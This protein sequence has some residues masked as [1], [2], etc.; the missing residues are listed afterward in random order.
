MSEKLFIKKIYGKK[1]IF[2]H[3]VNLCL[4]L[5]VLTRWNG[6]YNLDKISEILL[7]EVGL[8]CKRKKLLL[9][10]FYIK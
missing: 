4:T 7:N 3:G 6:L 5:T 10:Y 1:K 9:G 8:S 2:V